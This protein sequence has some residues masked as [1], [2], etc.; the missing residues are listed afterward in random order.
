MNKTNKTFVCISNYFKGADFLIHLKELGNTVFLITSEK[1][2]EKPWP[3]D[4]I[5]EIF[6]MPGQDVDWNLEDLLLG[7]GNLMKNNSIDAIV[8]LD[9]FDVEKA[10]F[11][12]ENLVYQEWG[13]QQAGILEIN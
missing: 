10:T 3:F 5:D 8:A 9:D 13:K 6:Y 1:L 4:H 7:V 12:R 2:K 11:L